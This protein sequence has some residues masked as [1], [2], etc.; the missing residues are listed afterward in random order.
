M[1]P[2]SQFFTRGNLGPSGGRVSGGLLGGKNGVMGEMF[3][4]F[5]PLQMQL[6]VSYSI[7]Q[8]SQF[9]IVCLLSASLHFVSSHNSLGGR[10]YSSLCL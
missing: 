3:V 4:S 10:Q 2:T 7:H 5:W 8:L 1:L 9:F 6:Q